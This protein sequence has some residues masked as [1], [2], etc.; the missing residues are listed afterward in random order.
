MDDTRQAAIAGGHVLLAGTGLLPRVTRRQYR[1]C[2]AHNRAAWLL[3]LSLLQGW[4]QRCDG[5][6]INASQC[7]TPGPAC[8]WANA[9]S[10]PQVSTAIH[11]NL[12][13]MACCSNIAA[14]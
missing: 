3:L 13:S 5:G 8:P 12:G 10:L 4:P 11:A 7:A 2:T 1:I 9:S 14:L 6:G